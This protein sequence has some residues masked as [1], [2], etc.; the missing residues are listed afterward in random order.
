MKAIQIFLLL[1]CLAGAAKAQELNCQVTVNSDQLFAQQKTDFSY[2]NQL[3]GIITELMNNRRWTNDQFACFGA[4]QLF[5][6]Y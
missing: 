5:T 3:K 2:V 6:E 1:I 4:N